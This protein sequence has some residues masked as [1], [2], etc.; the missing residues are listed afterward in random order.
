MPELIID[1]DDFISGPHP[2]VKPIEAKVINDAMLTLT[3]ATRSLFAKPRRESAVAEL[4][5][6]I[7]L[8]DTFLCDIGPLVS[9]AID[10]GLLKDLDL[11]ILDEKG[12]LGRSPSDEIKRAQD[13]D[14]FFHA[15][16]SVLHC[17]TSLSLYDVSFLQLDIHHILFDCCNQ[18]KHLYL[19]SCDVGPLWKIDAPNSKLRVLVLCCFEGIELI[20]LPKLEKLGVLGWVSHSAHLSFG[21]VPSLEELDLAQ[22]LLHRQHLYKLSDFLHGATGIHT[23]TLDS[24][25]RTIWL[26]PEIKQLTSAFRKLRKLLILGIFVE[27]DLLWTTTFLEAAPSIEMLHIEVCEHACELGDEND[28][29]GI[30]AERTNPW[31]ELDFHASKNMLLRELHIAHFRPLEQQVTFIRAI[32]ERAPNLQTVMLN[33]DGEICNECDAIALDA[34]PSALARH[35]FPSTKEEQDSVVRWVIDGTFFSGQIYFR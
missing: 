22:I 26:Q 14:G 23:L 33:K 2:R 27:F 8:I 34:P 5:L 4:Q 29:S 35:A 6:E 19:Y 31:W 10:R 20:S 28:E 16:P 7:Y 1:A 17:L 12:T 30:L 24:K 11:A 32:L 18:L 3:A 9:D 15:Y 13:I 25:G 21:F